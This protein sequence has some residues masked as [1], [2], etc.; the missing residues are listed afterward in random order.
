MTRRRRLAALVAA[1][2]VIVALGLVGLEVWRSV[3]PRASLF[4]PPFASSLAEAIATGNL[5]HAYE[6][7]RAGQDPNQRIAVRHPVLTPGPLGTD[8][9]AALVGGAPERGRGEDAAGLRGPPR[10]AGRPAGDMFLP[11]LSGT[12]TSGASCARPAVRRGRRPALSSDR[13]RRPCSG[14]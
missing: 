12:P 2:A 1:P 5:Q 8:I 4:A 6:Y 10:S 7:V 11:R 9:A 3:W 14:C 13:T